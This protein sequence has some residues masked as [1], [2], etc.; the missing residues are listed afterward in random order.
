MSSVFVVIAEALCEKETGPIF[1]PV[2]EQVK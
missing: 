1:G 2:C